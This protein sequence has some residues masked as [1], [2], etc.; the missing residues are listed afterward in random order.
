[1]KNRSLFCLV[2]FFSGLFLMAQN[3]RID[4]LLNLLK[5][6]KA[7]TLKAEHLNNLCTEYRKIGSNKEALEY[8]KQALALSL[9]LKKGLPGVKRCLSLSYTS[10]GN[11]YYN[12]SDYPNALENQLK[13]LK[14][15]EELGDAKLLAKRLG[16]LGNIYS[17]QGDYPKALDYYFRS[18]KMLEQLGDKTR[19]ISVISNIGIVYRNQNDNEKALDYYFKALKMAEELGDKMRTATILG[20]IGVAYKEQSKFKEALEFHLKALKITRELGDKNKIEANLGNIGVAYKDMGNYSQGL[21]YYLEALK[22]AE[23]TGDKNGVARHLGNIGLLYTKTGKFKEAE[24]SFLKAIALDENLGVTNDLRQFEEVLAQLYDT[25]GRPKLALIHYKRAMALKDT[26][27]TQEKNKDITRK[28]MS[29]EFEKKEIASK[30]E[31]DKQA[32]LA[33]AENKKQR[34]ITMATVFGLLL[35]ILFAGF[36][37]RSLRITRKQK[38]TIEEQ[39]KEVEEQKHLVEEKQREIVDSITYAKRLQEAILPPMVEIKK[40]FPESFLLYL[41]KDIVA[42]DFYWMEHLEERTFIAAADSTGHGV[43][44]AIVSVVCSNALNRSVKEFKER[45]TGKILDKTRELVLETF[46]KSSSE[47]K[48]GMDISLLAIDRKEKRVFWS[49]A[50]NQLWYVSNKEL[51]ELT[52]DKQ[53]IGK[54]D[55]P[56]PFKTHQ[57]ELKK[58]DVVY[59]MTDGYPDQFG[60][61][62]GKKYKYKQLEELLLTNS[63]KDVE[64]QKQLLERSFTAWKGNLEQVDDVTIIG[65]RL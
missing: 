29:F 49:G 5:T 51:I 16:N 31:F 19:I 55:N 53:P 1:M 32:S 64:A 26:L 58:G 8:G 63:E 2:F 25:T 3:P 35:A 28:E 46:E 4:S 45:D 37:F 6:D 61:P 38:N 62:K 54:T 41:P 40:R 12:L 7:D 21:E 10:V 42:G 15:D 14:V 9:E 18:L 20:N 59:L 56:R 23:E 57:L 60:G 48:D 30:A 65:I 52:A 33:A 17:D 39:K 13:G 50:N 11:T 43:P 22:V 36:I 47:V 44:G 34:I 24:Q 27:F